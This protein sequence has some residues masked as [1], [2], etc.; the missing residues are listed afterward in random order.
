M[1]VYTPRDVAVDLKIYLPIYAIIPL[2][3]YSPI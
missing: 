2:S 1:F 3:T